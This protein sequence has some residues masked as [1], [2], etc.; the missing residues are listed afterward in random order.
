[1]VADQSSHSARVAL[2]RE[3]RNRRRALDPAEHARLSAIVCQNL[4]RSPYF[5]RART[6]AGFISQDG[7]PDL[8]GLRNCALARGKR[9][10]LPA[11][12]GQRL[13]FLP[14]DGPMSLN[15]Y[16]IPEPCSGP[17]SRI[18]LLGLDLVLMPLVAFDGRCARLGMGGGYYDRTFGY[19]RHRESWRRP[20]LIGVAYEFQRI[21]EVPAEPWDVRLDGVM[22]ERGLTLPS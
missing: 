14:H 7:E 9:P 10:Y 15:R 13:W 4:I 2:R 17:D 12:R 11:I 20:R 18:G 1:M 6:Y 3:A 5:I 19:L 21:A 16:R 8:Q 22:T